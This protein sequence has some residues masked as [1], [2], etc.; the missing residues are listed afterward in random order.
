M[1]SVFAFT[2]LPIRLLMISGLIGFLFF[3]CLGIFVLISKVSGL[4]EVPGYATTILTI[5]FFAALNSLGLGVIGSYVWRAFE[6]TKGRPLSIVMTKVLTKAEP[7]KA[8]VN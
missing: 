2:D 7:Q 8:D 1:D 4:V 6:N 3:V 5:S